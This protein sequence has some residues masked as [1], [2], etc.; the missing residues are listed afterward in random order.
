MNVAVLIDNRRED[1][2]PSR[3][4]EAVKAAYVHCQRLAENERRFLQQARE[5]TKQAEDQRLW[6]RSNN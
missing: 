2:L 5:G 6:S 3:Q 4:Q 1:V